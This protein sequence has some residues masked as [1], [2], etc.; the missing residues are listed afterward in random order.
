MRIQ[1]VSFYIEKP[2]IFHLFWDITSSKIFEFFLCKM[3]LKYKCLLMIWHRFC[4]PISFYGND[5]LPCA[6]KSSKDFLHTFFDSVLAFLH[7]F[8]RASIIGFTHSCRYIC[9]RIAVAAKRNCSSYYICKMLSL[10]EC[11]YSF[12]NGFLTGFHVMISRSYFIAGS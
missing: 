10:K 1:S 2:F 9:K 12:G 8:F 6:Y 11:N 3:S 4:L 7:K 5:P